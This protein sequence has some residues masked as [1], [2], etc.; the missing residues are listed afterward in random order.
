MTAVNYIDIA[1]ES[2]ITSVENLPFSLSLSSCLLTSSLILQ[3]QCE[4][5]VD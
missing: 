5:K 2:N 1:F 3:Y 4:S